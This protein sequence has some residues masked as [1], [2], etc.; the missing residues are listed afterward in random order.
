[1]SKHKCTTYLLST[2]PVLAVQIIPLPGITLPGFAS[3]HAAEWFHIRQKKRCYRSRFSQ[4]LKTLRFLRHGPALTT[5]SDCRVGCEVLTVRHGRHIRSASW[6]LRAPVMGMRQNCLKTLPLAHDQGQMTHS[7]MGS[8]SVHTR[9]IR[10]MSRTHRYY[11]LMCAA[12]VPRLC[13][14]I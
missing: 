9:F 4:R 12:S 14:L 13:G 8:K 10:S 2:H 1:M 11:T 7:S 6:S 5:R 3:R